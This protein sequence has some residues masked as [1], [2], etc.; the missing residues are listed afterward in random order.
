MVAALAVVS[1]APKYCR[2]VASISEGV[3]T[4]HFDCSAGAFDFLWGLRLVEKIRVAVQIVERSQAFRSFRLR[5]SAGKA[6]A[7]RVE[8][9][10][11]IL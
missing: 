6:L 11:G 9:A 2:I 1:E 7:G 3:R 10:R 8:R 5:S 4:A